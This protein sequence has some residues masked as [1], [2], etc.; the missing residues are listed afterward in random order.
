LSNFELFS[1]IVTIA[2]MVSNVGLLFMN[3]SLRASMYELKVYMHENFHTKEEQRQL[4]FRFS[5][6]QR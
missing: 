5:D 6:K 2:A 3:L 1:L 4:P